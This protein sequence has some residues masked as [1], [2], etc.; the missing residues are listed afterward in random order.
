MCPDEGNSALVVGSALSAVSVCGSGSVDSVDIYSSA[1]GDIGVNVG[2]KT[3]LSAVGT[4]VGVDSTD[5]TVSSWYGVTGI[6]PDWVHVLLISG[7]PSWLPI[8]GYA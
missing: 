8:P 1:F 4:V 2:V 6:A 3:I 5:D 7:S